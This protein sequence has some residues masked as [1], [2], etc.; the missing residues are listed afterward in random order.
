MPLSGYSTLTTIITPIIYSITVAI[1][2]VF[3]TEYIRR[4]I[5]STR[6]RK[7]FLTA[8]KD[9]DKEFSKDYDDVQ[10]YINIS[11]SL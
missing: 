10:H 6:S 8:L 9:Y 5:S 7:I 1:I 2:T 11:L 3:F 4:R